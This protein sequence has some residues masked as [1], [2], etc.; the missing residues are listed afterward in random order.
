MS[1]GRLGGMEPGHQFDGLKSALKEHFKS[2]KPMGDDDLMALS[3]VHGL[4]KAGPMDPLD[5]ERIS[6]SHRLIDRMSS[7]GHDVVTSSDRYPRG[8]SVQIKNGYMAHLT[9]DEGPTV[10]ARISHPDDPSFSVEGTFPSDRDSPRALRS[11][12]NQQPD[13]LNAPISRMT[14]TNCGGEGSIYHPE[15]E[16]KARA[17]GMERPTTGGGEF[18][19]EFEHCSTCGG[20]GTVA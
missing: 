12:V 15:A 19:G 13:L 5:A 16:V 10:H 2:G 7:A 20:E 4:G 1:L 9:P 14:C 6:R 17:A 3:A 11:W 8:V 18:P